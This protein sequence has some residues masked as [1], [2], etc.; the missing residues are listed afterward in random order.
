VP[1][2][3]S[4]W[5]TFYVITGSSGAA[6]TGLMFVVITLAAERFK[7][8][9]RVKPSEE[10]NAFSTPTVVHFGVVLL[11]ASIMTVPHV[12]RLSLGIGLLLCAAVGLIYN[13]SSMRRMRRL[14]LYTAVTED[15][16]WH[17]IL[18]FVAYVSLLTGV[19]LLWVENGAAL[20]VVAGFVL[21]LL[22]IGI[23][24]AWDVALYTALQSELALIEPQPGE[25]PPGAAP[26]S[27]TSPSA[28]Q[29]TQPASVADA[30]R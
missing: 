12:N 28:A 24:N 8:P 10:M 19:T 1:L 6:L 7:D 20:H 17:V 9:R 4:E 22:F 29:E 15:W 26:P 18:P 21:L 5:E 13:I 23:H 11:V 30:S 25:A 3:L 2:S 14:K 16:I 27:A